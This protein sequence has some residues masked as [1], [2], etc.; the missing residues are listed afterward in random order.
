M[1][2][3]ADVALRLAFRALSALEGGE[4]V[5]RYPDGRGR[6]FGDA[7]GPSFTVQLHDPDAFW[8]KLGTKTRV[9]FGES[10]V[11]GDWDCDDLV[12][13]FSLLGRNLETAG[14]HPALQRLYR[15]QELRPDRRARQTLEV[16]KDSIHA[17]Y[18]LGN[19]LFELMLDPTMTY[20][21]AYWERPGMTLE[22]GQR[23]KIRH[24]CEKI[25]LGPG[26]HVL[27][28]GC[29]WGSFAIQAASEVG[30]RVTALT[31]SPSQARLARER[32][33]AAGLDDLVEIREQ[34]YRLTRGQFSRIVSI[35]MFEAIG[36]AEYENYFAAVDRLLTADGVACVQ[37]IGVPDWR[38]ERYRR[39][40]DWIQQ[41]IFPGSLLPSLEAITK[42]VAVTRL[43]VHGVEEIGFGY[44]RTLREWRENVCGNVDR[45]R[46][47]GY[48]ERFLRL[49]TF[50]LTYCEA[51]FAIRSLRDMQLVL[52]HSANDA[53]PE[54][55]SVRPAY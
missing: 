21:C 16:A 48:D 32:V 26:D 6:R 38:F 4:V 7:D 15:L 28:I 41:V 45:L 24:I 36:L 44:A 47:L 18:D 3:A 51:G 54:F 31:L 8:R 33:F 19:D 49:W 29:G 11:D 35:E 53:L 5:L 30:C 52:V 25:R 40:P 50:Y 12:G 46:E 42:A 34:D 2:L 9:G 27:E 55:P 23:A 13:L 14:S 1:R 43:Q 37:T 20:S 17:H 22:E 10:Y 39:R